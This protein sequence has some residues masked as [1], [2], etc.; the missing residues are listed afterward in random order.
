MLPI[1]FESIQT[2][3]RCVCLDMGLSSTICLLTESLAVICR[4]SCKLP[5]HL[6]RVKGFVAT[7]KNNALQ[8]LLVSDWNP[9][10][11]HPGEAVRNHLHVRNHLYVHYRR[12][13]AYNA[14]R[15]LER[16]SRN[17][18]HSRQLYL[19]STPSPHITRQNEQR[20]FSLA[21]I[22]STTTT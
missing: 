5:L 12:Q 16:S 21:F 14:P 8:L 20:N 4:A 10:R 2:M 1:T 18:K 9:P 11:P 15:L 6:D 7:V 3:L 22:Y 13:G 19:S 17:P